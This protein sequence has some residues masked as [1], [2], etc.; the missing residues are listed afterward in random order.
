MIVLLCRLFDKA[1]AFLRRRGWSRKVAG[2][3]V[4]EPFDTPLDK[5]I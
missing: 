3:G 5:P 2:S 4:L 1:A